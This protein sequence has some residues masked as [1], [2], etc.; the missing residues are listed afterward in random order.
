MELGNNEHA[1]KPDTLE[2][3]A[4]LL[5]KQ[6]CQDETWSWGLSPRV[7]KISDN[8]EK[9][10]TPNV[11]R[12]SI[13]RHNFSRENRGSGDEESDILLVS[14]HNFVI[15]IACQ[16]LTRIFLNLR[17]Y[18]FINFFMNSYWYKLYLFSVFSQI[19]SYTL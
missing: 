12:K 15:K 2:I 6:D 7:V 11:S 10:L 3:S 1:I 16:F 17:I 14:S 19:C 5:A 9:A 18:Y 13:S 8:K 4:N